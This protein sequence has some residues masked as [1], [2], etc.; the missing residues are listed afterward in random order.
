MYKNTNNIHNIKIFPAAR[1]IVDFY[2]EIYSWIKF[3][4]VFLCSLYKTW[5]WFVM[6]NFIHASIIIETFKIHP[7]I[8]LIYIYVLNIILKFGALNYRGHIKTTICTIGN[9]EHET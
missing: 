7:N 6:N 4:N 8:I 9:S 2:V 5:V 3:Q 1:V